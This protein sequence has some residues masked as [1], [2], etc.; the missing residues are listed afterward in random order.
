MP[1]R[2][3]DREAALAA[4]AASAATCT[5]CELYRRATQTVFGEGPVTARIMLVG[6]QPGDR[7]DIEGHPFVG[8]AGGLLDAALAAAGIDPHEAYVTNAV[9]HFKW[10]PRGTRRIHQRPTV[11]EVNAC[12][13]WLEE[14]VRL[15]R[16]RVVVCLGATAARAVLGR[17]T[18]ISKVRGQLVDGPGDVPAVVTIHPSAVLR[19]RTDEDRS[20]MRRGLVADLSLARQA[21]G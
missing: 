21:A 5:R 7:E 1:D 18:T 12:H 11:S 10:E 3:A 16:P 20:A 6:E 17:A 13:V 9:K 15:V 8:P 2:R 4:Q 14:E 19:A